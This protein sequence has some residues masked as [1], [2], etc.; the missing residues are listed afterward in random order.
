MTAH[1]LLHARMAANRAGRGI[2]VRGRRRV[3]VDPACWRIAGASRR[4][5]VRRAVRTGMPEPL[6]RGV[7]GTGV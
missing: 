3:P 4:W 1:E 7:G 2:P 6:A 5:D